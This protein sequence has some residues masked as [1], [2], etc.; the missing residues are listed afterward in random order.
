MIFYKND[1]LS[2]LFKQMTEKKQ[3]IFYTYAKKIIE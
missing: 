2:Q 3:L 1:L